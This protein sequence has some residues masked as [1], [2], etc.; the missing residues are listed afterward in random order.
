MDATGI[1]IAEELAL[2]T[3]NPEMLFHA[4]GSVQIMGTVAPFSS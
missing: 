4:T 1:A 3:G 2:A